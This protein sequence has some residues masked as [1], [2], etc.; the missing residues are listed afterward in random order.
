MQA[1]STELTRALEIRRRIWLAIIGILF[2]G[3]CGFWDDREH[4][5]AIDYG[6]AWT[7]IAIGVG[8]LFAL[9]VG[10]YWYDRYYPAGAKRA[11]QGP[12]LQLGAIVCWAVAIFCISILG[13]NLGF[14][15]A[16]V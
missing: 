6:S 1:S 9:T 10:L 4:H 7:L 14:V 15:V 3:F 16:A 12:P 8:G 11:I 5:I 13:F 2:F